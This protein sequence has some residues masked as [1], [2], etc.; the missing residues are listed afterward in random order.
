MAGKREKFGGARKARG[1]LTV[2]SSRKSSLPSG[3]PTAESAAGAG[4][5]SIKDGTVVVEVID[6]VS[7]EVRVTEIPK[8]WSEE[9][10]GGLLLS[11]SESKD[12]GMIPGFSELGRGNT[13]RTR[14]GVVTEVGTGLSNILKDLEG[15][16]VSSRD[17]MPTGPSI[18]ATESTRECWMLGRIKEGVDAQEML[19]NYRDIEPAKPNKKRG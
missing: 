3:S 10:A 2:V 13:P 11:L 9:G 4:R 17:G 16:V 14:E 15:R 12:I 8:A 1:V 7:A 5:V 18:P 6:E 19:F